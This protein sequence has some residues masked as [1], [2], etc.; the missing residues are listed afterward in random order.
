MMSCWANHL[1]DIV[2]DKDI[3]LEINNNEPMIARTSPKGQ[4]GGSLHGQVLHDKA[5]INRILTNPITA[6]EH[7]HGSPSR[8]GV[9]CC[10]CLPEI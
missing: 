6:L 4:P 3:R 9:P 1:K 7:S 8:V 10:D 5:S 2:I